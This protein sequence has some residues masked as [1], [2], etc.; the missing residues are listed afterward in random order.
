MDQKV[1]RPSRK[2][3]RSNENEN[4]VKN[5]DDVVHSVK[6][7]DP[8]KE[9]ATMAMVG[10]FSIPII[11]RGDI[12]KFYSAAKVLA[13]GDSESSSPA[14]TDADVITR[15]FEK[16]QAVYIPQFFGCPRNDKDEANGCVDQDIIDWRDLSDV[17]ENLNVS[18]KQSFCIENE[19]AA[20]RITAENGHHEDGVDNEEMDASGSCFLKDPPGGKG[21]AKDNRVGYCSFVV[22]NDKESLSRLLRKLPV[23]DP[24]TR[25]AGLVGGDGERISSRGWDYDP[26]LWIFFGRNNSV[27]GSDLEGRPEHTDQISHDGTW[28]YQL[29]GTKRWLLRPTPQ[30]L[31]M[32]KEDLGFSTASDAENE[33]IDR[34]SSNSQNE[35]EEGIDNDVKQMRIDCEKG[36]VL[37]VNTR[38]WRHQTVLPPQR[39]PSISY[40]RDFWIHKDRSDSDRTGTAETATAGGAMTNVD[41]LYAMDD[42]AEDTVI[43]KE[44]DMPDCELHRTTDADKANCKVVELEDGIQAVVSSKFIKAGEFFC[45]P[46]SSDE[47]GSDGDDDD[48]EEGEGWFEDVEE[49]DE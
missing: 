13:G 49:D 33:K 7:F 29:S 32:W 17:Y 10:V 9:T 24:V 42:I 11:H 5:D 34:D 48:E 44:D 16:Y 18:D 25:A 12:E 26:C 47:E 2:R 46:E 31:R 36:D 21:K 1:E 28:H 40:A 19:G 27:P 23:R 4:E 20:K 6:L 37:I 35:T 14:S 22:Q 38:L 39:E 15:T 30:L 8:A 41:G 3:Q 43:F 45:I